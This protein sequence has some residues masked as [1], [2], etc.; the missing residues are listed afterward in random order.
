MEASSKS[1]E[2]KQYTPEHLEEVVLSGPHANDAIIG[3]SLHLIYLKEYL[4]ELGAQSMVIEH[5]Y[6]DRDFL[7]D[8]AS[9]YVRCLKSYERT[10]RRI[11]FF[12]QAFKQED[13]EQLLAGETRSLTEQSL[14]ASYLGF[15]VLKPL[16]ETVIGRTC[17]KPYEP[18]ERRFYPVVRTYEVHLY[19]LKL[20]IKSIAFQEQDTVTSAC[21]TS[22][23]WSV[24]QG[25]SKLYQHRVPSP[26]EITRLATR[27]SPPVSRVLPNTEG[28]SEWQMAQAI[29]AVALE[30]IAIGAANP[31][32][33]KAYCYAYMKSHVPV[34][35]TVVL[36]D[37]SSGKPELFGHH[38]VALTGFSLPAT[39]SP[40]P[41]RPY[42]ML[43]SATRMDKLYAHDDG[44]GPFARMEF[45]K[46]CLSTSWKGKDGKIGSVKAIPKGLLISVYHKIRISFL[47][48]FNVVQDFD[49]FVQVCRKDTG[50]LGGKARLE[51]DIYL[52][53]VN[54]VKESIRN[55][56]VLDPTYKLSILYEHMPR[57]IWRATAL[58]DGEP[59]IDLLF[60]ATD[61][62]QGDF[63][64]RAIEYEDDLAAGLR[65]FSPAA[66]IEDW[67]SVRP[68][69]FVFA[70]LQ[71]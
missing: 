41:L 11:H 70:W 52:T 8:F 20:E 3:R 12:S 9:Y 66:D 71:A 2:V 51:W 7:E 26:V 48:I 30:P 31:F 21:A 35:L 13:F 64:F 23:L 56:P 36:N 63:F 67:M 58:L 60:D 54:E 44:I 27:L 47:A 16:P 62:E 61:I 46:S 49:A 38:A 69:K 24:F 65:A 22:A 4:K 14:Q 59:V 42:G 6:V 40:L 1:I 68:I 5:T 29:R 50:C 53:T 17:L 18:E 33:L 10:C 37:W 28:L 34:L 57:F 39:T 25:T 15:I 19:G 45:E 55:C 43:L 32:V